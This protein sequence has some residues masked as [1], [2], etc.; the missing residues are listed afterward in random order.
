MV[1]AIRQNVTVQAGGVVQVR[2]PDLKPG[3]RAEVIVLV[4]DQAEF[5]R[6]LVSFIGAGR[7]LF[8][9]VEEVDGYIRELRDEWDR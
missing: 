2:S 5:P 1:A 3:A 6:S 4:E 8:G 9:S 7:G